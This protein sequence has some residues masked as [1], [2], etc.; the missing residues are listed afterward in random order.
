M[1][2]H[3]RPSRA[4]RLLPSREPHGK[5]SRALP[6]AVGS[7][8]DHLRGRKGSPP[9][10]ALLSGL[11]GSGRVRI[12]Q[13]RS[14]RM[15]FRPPWPRSPS[16]PMSPTR[17]AERGRLQLRIVAVT[18]ADCGSPTTR[19]V[20]RSRR[21]L[22]CRI[23][24]TLRHRT[25]QELLPGQAPRQR[26]PPSLGPS[27]ARACQRAVPRSQSPPVQAPRVPALFQLPSARRL[28]L[29]GCVHRRRHGASR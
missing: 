18:R 28:R 21:R 25:P 4:N 9:E 11:G 12:R 29:C 6:R 14:L 16:V 1:R 23:L 24:P 19:S 2:F 3:L 5:A 13:R 15:A 26:E 17:L 27:A 8:E 7:A 10:R 20:L 22:A